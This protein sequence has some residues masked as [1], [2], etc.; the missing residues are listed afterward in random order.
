MPVVH[1]Q[2]LRHYSHWASLAFS[3]LMGWS[4]CSLLVCG[5]SPRVIFLRR[6]ER[7]LWL[8]ISGCLHCRG[9]ALFSNSDTSM[10]HC[11]G[12]VIHVQES[13]LIPSLSTQLRVHSVWLRNLST[14]HS[15]LLSHIL[16]I[17]SQPLIAGFA[18]MT[19]T[20]PLLVVS[21]SFLVVVSLL[22]FVLRAPRVTVAAIPSLFFGLEALV[23]QGRLEL[24]IRSRCKVAHIITSRVVA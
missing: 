14:N 2:T 18:S 17:M 3:F 24:H 23:L 12:S 10:R 21:L 19:T 6:H 15:E 9:S 11:R 20:S 22:P 13:V 1:A 4:P 7:W 8:W 5:I 16:R